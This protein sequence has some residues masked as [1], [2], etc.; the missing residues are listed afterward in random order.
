MSDKPISDLRRRMIA[1]MTIRASATRRS[2]TISD[3][4]RLLLTSNSPVFPRLKD[5]WIFQYKL[6]AAAAAAL[7]I[8][9]EWTSGVPFL[10]S[11][12]STGTQSPPEQT[13]YASFFT[14][15]VS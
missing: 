8:A 15:H 11:A 14:A 7:K 10:P 13:H 5:V 12:E 9:G 3:M 4:S 6:L 1:D 2:A